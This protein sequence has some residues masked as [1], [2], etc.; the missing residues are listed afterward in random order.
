MLVM[1]RSL[2]EDMFYPGNTEQLKSWVFEPHHDNCS[3][4]PKID[5]QKL[6]RQPSTFFPHIPC[7]SAAPEMSETVF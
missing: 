2:C 3:V 5:I 6:S 4:W 1:V 7:T